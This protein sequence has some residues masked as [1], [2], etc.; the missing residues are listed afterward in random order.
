[1]P[2]FVKVGSAALGKKVYIQTYVQMVLKCV[3][4]HKSARDS[5]V[6]IAWSTQ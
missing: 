4:Y 6:R 2:S 1:M 3:K 5:M